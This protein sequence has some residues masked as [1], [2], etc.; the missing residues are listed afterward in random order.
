MK[1]LEKIQKGDAAPNR[2]AVLMAVILMGTVFGTIY[3]LSHNLLISISI[4]LSLGLLAFFIFQ[5]MIQ[6]LILNKIKTIYRIIQTTQSRKPKKE[7]LKGKDLEE[8]QEDVI[9]WSRHRAEE[10]KE[11]EQ[12]NEFR[13]EFLQNLSHELKTPIFTIQGYIETLQ[14]GAIDDRDVAVRFL[15]NA[16]KGVERLVSLAKSLDNISKLESG[17]LILDQKDFDYHKMMQDIYEELTLEA[18]ERNITL[19]HPEKQEK[20]LVHGDLGLLKQAVVNLVSNSL[21]YCSPGDEILY[22]TF[23]TDNKKVMIEVSDT[24]PGIEEEHLNRIFERFY[25]TDKSRSRNIGGSGLGLSITKH[26]LEAHKETIT[27]RS[28]LG[29]GTTFAFTLAKA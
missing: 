4:G 28:K 21:K 19:V 2:I 10:V 23:S 11:L 18:N 13:K 25:R 24:G 9:Q 8:V 22:R 12:N 3:G 15:N 1:I 20:L 5:R 27:C 14:E 26:I 6:G 29:K 17:N 16:N 7:D